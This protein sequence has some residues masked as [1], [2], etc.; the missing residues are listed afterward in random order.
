M[1]EEEG[2]KW[3]WYRE[4]RGGKERKKGRRKERMGLL[5]VRD[6]KRGE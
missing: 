5:H 1:K 4:M 2:E 3:E 6:K